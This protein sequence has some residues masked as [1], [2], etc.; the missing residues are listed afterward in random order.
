M[1][2][3]GQPA[4]GCMPLVVLG[5]VAGL[6]GERGE[7]RAHLERARSIGEEFG[8]GWTR[9][10]A[11]WAEGE[12]GIGAGAYEDAIAVLEP[13]AEAS[14]AAGWAS[15]ASRGGR[16][17]SPRPTSGP[18]ARDAEATLDVLEAQAERTGR[19]LARAGAARC[20]G[21]LAGDEEFAAHFERALAWHDGVAS[22]FERARTDLCFGERLRRSRRRCEARVPL[23]RALAAFE[24]L[25]AEPWAERARRELA[26]TGERARRRE[27]S[28]ADRL[29][30]Q[31]LQVAH[32]VAGG[33]TYKEAASALFVTQKTIESHLN[34]AYRKLG[35]RS[36]V[37]LPGMLSRDRRSKP[38]PETNGLPPR[39]VSGMIGRGADGGAPRDPGA[40]RPGRAA[41]RSLHARRAGG[42]A[43]GR[44]RAGADRALSRLP[45]GTGQA[46]TTQLADHPATERHVRRGGGVR[47]E[48]GARLRPATSGRRRRA[49]PTGAP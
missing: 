32:L 1:A 47:R 42:G 22:P 38:T 21:M 41:R 10:M 5:L 33:A 6:Q 7:A 46:P 28:T 36:R 37:E 16:R 15:P 31:E 14:R 20:R 34:H 39:A 30:P 24:T 45:T 48:A 35:I 27:P 8:L 2:P 19:Y 12:L 9:I 17:I 11:G 29:T 43:G 23:R 18:G 44:A 3:V 25:G 13:T 49:G 40:R 4:L 26:A